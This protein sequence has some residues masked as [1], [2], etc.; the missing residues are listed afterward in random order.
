MAIWARS[1]NTTKTSSVIIIIPQ[2]RNRRS[3]GKSTK[4]TT[5]NRWWNCVQTDIYKKIKNGKERSRNRVDWV[6]SIK[7]VK[8]CIGL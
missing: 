1:L 8:V 6:K 3:P 7:E 5:K 4:R 2:V